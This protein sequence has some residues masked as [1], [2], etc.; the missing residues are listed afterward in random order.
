MF[1]SQVGILDGLSVPNMVSNRLLRRPIARL[2]VLAGARVARSDHRAVHLLDVQD[3]GD[4]V[5]VLARVQV[6]SAAMRNRGAHAVDAD[7]H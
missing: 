4:V 1:V 7:L 6:G 3:G 5:N 2:L